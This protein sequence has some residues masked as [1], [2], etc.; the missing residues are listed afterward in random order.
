MLAGIITPADI[1]SEFFDLVIITAILSL[2]PLIKL[3]NYS[4][5]AI[6]SCIVY[7]FICLN[8]WFIFTDAYSSACPEYSAY[9]W[10]IF[11]VMLG[12][13]YLAAHLPFRIKSLLPL[14]IIA[15]LTIWMLTLADWTRISEVMGAFE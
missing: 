7:A 9:I 6:L 2:L 13:I 14:V 15:L 10:P 1:R 5:S 12:I 11:A 4:T 3:R 8:A